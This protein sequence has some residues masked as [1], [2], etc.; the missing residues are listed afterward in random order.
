MSG[1]YDRP[2][3][4]WHFPMPVREKRPAGQEKHAV[5][6]MHVAYTHQ[7]LFSRTGMGKCHTVLGRSYTPDIACRTGKARND[8]QPGM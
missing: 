5:H 7:D 6:Q 8:P 1:V 2:N 3:T 4:V